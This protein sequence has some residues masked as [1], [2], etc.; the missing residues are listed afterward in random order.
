M[1]SLLLGEALAQLVHQGL[2]AA[3]ALDG[4][5]LLGGQQL[6][7]QLFQPFAGQGGLADQGLDGDRLESREAFREGAVIAVDVAFVLDQDRAADGVEVVHRP[8]R[9][10]GLHR[11]HQVEP[12]PQGNRNPVA[13]QRVEERAE[14]ASAPER[15]VDQ[16]CD[17]QRHDGEDELMDGRVLQA[18]LAV[19]LRPARPQVSVVQ[20]AARVVRPRDRDEHLGALHP[21]ADRDDAVGKPSSAAA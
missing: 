5:A 6:L 8:A 9:H 20:A 1:A 19:P 13:A 16:D 3:R 10:P 15:A 21:A 12:F 14:H 7:G 4:G 2:E 17:E 18:V 11:G